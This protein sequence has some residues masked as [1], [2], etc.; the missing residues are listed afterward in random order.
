MAHRSGPDYSGEYYAELS[1]NLGYHANTKSHNEW[2]G[3]DRVSAGVFEKHAFALERFLNAGEIP[4]VVGEGNWVQLSERTGRGGGEG[5]L[6]LSSRRFIF[7]S[8]SDVENIA[9]PLE[10]VSTA[11]TSWIVIPRFVELH[12]VGSLP[13][14]ESRS[15]GFYCTK[16]TAKAIISGLK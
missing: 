4:L 14:G 12:I 9:I 13:S 10:Q 16:R 15:F 6:M 5:L 3:M 7:L 1:I 11:R 2:G 8:H